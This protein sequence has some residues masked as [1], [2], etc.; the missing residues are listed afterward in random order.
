MAA[1]ERAFLKTCFRMFRTQLRLISLQANQLDA[2]RP[3]IRSTGIGSKAGCAPKSP[4]KCSKRKA[5]GDV[6]KFNSLL[7]RPKRKNR[8]RKPRRACKR[9]QIRA[10]S[11]SVTRVSED[12]RIGNLNARYTFEEFVIGKLQPVR[13]RRLESSRSDAPAKA[14]NP[15]FLYG[16]V[17]LGK[18][19]LHARYRPSREDKMTRGAR[20]VYATKAKN[21][22]MNSSWRCKNNQKAT[23]SEINT[24]SST[25]C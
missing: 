11:P 14:Y 18:T 24:G 9:Q 15:L 23:S 22:R 17:G 19:H 1:L 8:S 25:F 5:F 4:I 16:G 12:P 6:D 7:R 21:L 3:Q 10:F 2:F 13:A 20:I